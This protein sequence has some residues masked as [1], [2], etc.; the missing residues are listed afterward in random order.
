MIAIIPNSVDRS[1]INSNT[2]LNPVTSDIF[3][4]PR[5]GPWTKVGN[6]GLS[7]ISQFGTFLKVMVVIWHP[8]RVYLVIP[9]VVATQHQNRITLQA[10]KLLRPQ[11][12][13]GWHL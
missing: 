10:P 1:H 4:G 13:S 5:R 7:R 3:C 12:I 2:K 11:M 8:N 6:M 9:W